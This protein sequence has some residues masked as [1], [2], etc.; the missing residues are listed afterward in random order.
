MALFYESR[1]DSQPDRKAAGIL[2]NK[3]ELIK[4]SECLKGNFEAFALIQVNFSDYKIRSSNN[5]QANPRKPDNVLAKVHARN[6]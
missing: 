2:K 6:I 1:K 5:V 4:K 3:A